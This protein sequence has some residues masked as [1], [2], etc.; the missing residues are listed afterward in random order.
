MTLDS[1]PPARIIPPPLLALCAFALCLVLA[2]CA[3]GRDGHDSIRE[4]PMPPLDAL[5]GDWHVAGRVPWFGERGR[6]ASRIRLAMADG[7][8]LDVTR[9]WREGFAEPVESDTSSARRD[10]HGDRLWKMRTYGVLPTRL[11]MLE[12]AGDGSWMLLDSPGRDHAWILTR[13]QETGDEAYLELERR[14]RRHGVNTDKLRRV[15]Q[16]P[17]QEGRLGFEPAASPTAGR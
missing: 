11:R 6:V 15:P 13:A 4:V 5:M 16:L 1:R 9:S 10:G 7:D 17:E 14:I 2:A 12:V 8:R 3:S